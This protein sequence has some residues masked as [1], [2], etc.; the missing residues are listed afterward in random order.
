[1]VRNFFLGV[2]ALLLSGVGASSHAQAPTVPDISARGPQCQLLYIALFLSVQLDKT[3]VPKSMMDQV[4]TSSLSQMDAA[5]RAEYDRMLKQ[6][7]PSQAESVIGLKAE[8]PLMTCAARLFPS[9]SAQSI[10]Q[11]QQTLIAAPAVAAFRRA[12]RDIEDGMVAGSL[13]HLQAGPIS[14]ESFVG[15]FYAFPTPA[16]QEPFAISRII[17]G[18]IEKCLSTY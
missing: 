2:S 14:T 3:E 11:C 10:S 9:A 17:G 5:T 8:K 12:G 6:G 15:Y 4:R 1:M 13:K 7:D 16:Y 18:W